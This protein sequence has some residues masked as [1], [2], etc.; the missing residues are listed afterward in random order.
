MRAAIL[1]TINKAVLYQLTP[2]KLQTSLRKIAGIVMLTVALC[3]TAS[4]T[5]VLN[6]TTA[7]TLGDPTQSGRLSRNGL[8]QD[9]ANTEPFPGVVNTATIYHYRTFV[10]DPFT[11]ALG[12]FMQVSLDHQGPNRGTLF[13]SAYLTS[14]NPNSTATGNRGFDTNWLGDAGSS[15]NFFGTDPTFFQVTVPLGFSL[16]IVISNTAAGNVGVGDQ[17]NLLVESFSDNQ[18]SPASLPDAGTSALLLGL[19]LS[20]LFVVQRL[21]VRRASAGP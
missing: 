19:G 10:I 2:M 18:Y 17:F 7:L 6:T 14:Y 13:A 11:V 9:W 1:T 15:G 20:G 12:H 8:N 5:D 16:V 3:A 4:A 21:S